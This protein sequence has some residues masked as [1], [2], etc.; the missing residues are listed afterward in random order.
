MCGIVGLVSRYSNGFSQ[1]EANALTDMLVIDSFR[2]LDSTGTFSVDKHSNVEI[3]KQASHGLDFVLEKDFKD[4][5]SNVIRSGVIAVGH[6]RAAT[7]GDV[8]DKNAHPFYVDDKIVLVQNGTM[9]GD[10]KTLAKGSKEVEVDSEA[11]AHLLSE[12]ADVEKALQKVNA[13]YVLVWFNADTKKLYMIRNNERPLFYAE[14]EPFGM[15]FASEIHTINYACNKYNLKFG[16]IKELPPGE[17]LTLDLSDKSYH[18]QKELTKIDATYRFQGQRHVFN[19]RNWYGNLMGYDDDVE[20]VSRT[21]SENTE[22]IENTLPFR[23]KQETSEVKYPL[24]PG[25]SS[26]GRNNI[27]SNYHA[28]HSANDLRIQFSDIAVQNLSE[29]HIGTTNI[30]GVI[31]EG[32]KAAQ[33]DGRT[34][35]ETKGFFPTNNHHN[36]RQWWVYGEIISKE[37][38]DNLKSIVVYWLIHE[39][40][41][42]EIQEYIEKAFFSC[43]IASLQSELF[44]KGE[45]KMA[46]VRGFATSAKPFLEPEV[47]REI[48]L[49]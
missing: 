12:E 13:A 20:T 1:D 36:C 28:S 9:R 8:N 41:R 4:W 42:L 25:P 44:T 27:T 18:Y 26:P 34:Y 5:R 3:I 47:I 35:V 24:L 17:L 40:T 21:P 2:G 15:I 7:R 33:E 48:K 49:S 6:N 39:M 45:T 46:L 30:N 16:N 19:E 38:A 14:N 22:V 43:R 31:E 23:R 10:H 32:L 11:I 29:Y 37:D